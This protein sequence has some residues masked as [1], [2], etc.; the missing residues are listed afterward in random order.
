MVAAIRNA[1]FPT[2]LV[3]IVCGLWMYADARRVIDGPNPFHRRPQSRAAEE[4]A[5]GG[6]D[7]A[8][9]STD[10]RDVTVATLPG[11]AGAP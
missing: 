1:S 9:P 8:G 10:A 6:A 11:D 3:V 5:D 2:L 4:W 7:P